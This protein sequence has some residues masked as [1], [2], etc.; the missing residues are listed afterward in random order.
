MRLIE[1]VKSHSSMWIKEKGVQYRKFYWQR[2][3]GSFSVN[4]TEIDVVRQYIEKQE[5]H[6]KHRSFQEEFRAFLK[7]YNVKYDERYVWD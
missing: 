1:E 5:E 2:G 4:P 3:Y 6:H 7:K